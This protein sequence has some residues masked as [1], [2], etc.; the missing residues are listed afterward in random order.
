MIQIV[1]CSQID[2]DSIRKIQIVTDSITTIQLDTVSIRMIQIVT[3]SIRLIQIVT[4]SI[5]V[6]QIVTHSIRKKQIVTN[7]M[8]R[9]Q[10]GKY[11]RCLG[12]HAGVILH[13][14][15]GVSHSFLASGSLICFSFLVSRRASDSCLWFGPP[16][17]AS[18]FRPP[19]TGSSTS[20]PGSFGQV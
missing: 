11:S 13:V 12:S 7:S 5:G 20:S 17:P 15:L 9:I 18:G 2:T 1:T 19:P 10:I 16:A 3:D 14:F 4:D 6:I 8:R